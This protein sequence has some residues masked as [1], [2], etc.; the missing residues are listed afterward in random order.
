M[1]TIVSY[2]FRTPSIKDDTKRR[3]KITDDI[4]EGR[5]LIHFYTPTTLTEP[6]HC[7]MDVY[8]MYTPLD[9]QLIRNVCSKGVPTSTYW[10]YRRHPKHV[11]P[12]YWI[13]YSTIA[14]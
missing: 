11:S 12:P 1:L 5:H 14:L 7:S 9:E 10:R 3:P 4:N 2:C 13:E 6:D 8:Q